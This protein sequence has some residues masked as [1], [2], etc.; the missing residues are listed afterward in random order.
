MNDG[1]HTD[2][3]CRANTTYPEIVMQAHSAPL[4]IAFYDFPKDTSQCKLND[5]F[6]LYMNSSAI[7]GF[8]GSW[9][10]DIPTGYKVV[11]Q[12]MVEGKANKSQPLDLFANAKTGARWDSGLR[13]VDVKFDSCGRLFVTS[14]GTRMSSDSQTEG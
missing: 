9:N 1:I 11:W 3:W 13:P 14:D 7:I 12:L 6:P 5:S 2:E 10:R 4:G 8:H